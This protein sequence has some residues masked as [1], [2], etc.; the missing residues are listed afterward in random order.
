MPGVK[1]CY[2]P[3][4]TTPTWGIFTPRYAR[5]RWSV[6]ALE[7][8][9]LW[10]LHDHIFLTAIPGFCRWI[11]WVVSSLLTMSRI[12]LCF[13]LS[14]FGPVLGATCQPRAVLLP[15]K[16]QHL[17]GGGQARGVLFQIGGPNSQSV[18]LAP[19]ALVL[20]AQK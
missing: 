2:S 20:L 18:A 19:S 11:C 15:F 13:F 17:A 5:R 3:I 16:N 14:F 4:R 1:V 6:L 12:F 7:W 10:V 9:A 8:E